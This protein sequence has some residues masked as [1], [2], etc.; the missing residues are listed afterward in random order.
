[1][2]KKKIILIISILIIIILIGVFFFY[3]NSLVKEKPINETKEEVNNINIEEIEIKKGSI[4]G[5]LS[6]PAINI[7]NV[8][9]C[10][11]VDLDVLSNSIGHFENTNLFEGNVGLASHNSGTNANYFKD[12]YKLKKGDEIIYKS[13]YGTITYIVESISQID[14]YDWSYLESTQDNRITL[15]TCISG[16]PNLRLCVQGVEKT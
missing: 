7:N 5:T 1:M 13:R 10:E 16:K 9:V 6:I 14:S 11:S 2:N 12:L 4:I 3:K 8:N 15:I